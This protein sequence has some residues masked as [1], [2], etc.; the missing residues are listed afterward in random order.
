VV[1]CELEGRSRREAADALLV[2]EGTISS[3]LAAAHRLLEKRLRARGFTGVVLAAL[4]AGPGVASAEVTSGAV[5][6]VAHPSRAVSQLA[7]EVTKMHLLHKLGLGAT[8]FAVAVGVAVAA[9]GAVP[10]GNR[11]EPPNPAA[12]GA[13]KSAEPKPEPKPEPAWKA[14]FRKVYGLKDGELVRRVAPPYPECRAEYF[15]DRTREHFKWLKT[16]PPESELARDYTDYFTKFGWKDGWTVP[17]LIAHTTP[18]KPD[19]GESLARV[20]ESTT[21]F[22]RTRFDGD[23][24]LLGTKVTGDWVVRAGAEPDK[25]VTALEKVLRK[26]CDLRVTLAIKEEEREVYVLS[27]TYATKPLAERKDHEIEVYA[28]DLHSRE[29]GGGGSGRLQELAEHVEGWIA[30]PIVLGEIE[31]APK[32]VSWHY[33][34]RMKFTNDEYAE[35]HDPAKVMANVAAQT[36]LTAKLEKRKIKVLVAKKGS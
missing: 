34:E 4:L 9:G 3:R 2:A 26:E 11:A 1:L 23:A 24:D 13:A 21:G 25:L 32:R 27:G 14:E 6:A 19:E 12:A 15:I 29:Y 36:G 30:T 28:T 10:H 31:A 8:A 16:D 33:N 20:L 35:D 17:A 22:Q 7:S 18:V 5:R